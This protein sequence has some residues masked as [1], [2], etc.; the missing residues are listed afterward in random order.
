MKEHG[1]LFRTDMVRAILEGGKT[2]TRRLV[3]L[4]PDKNHPEWPWQPLD[5]I[6][7]KEGPGWVTLMQRNPGRGGM[8]DYPMHKGDRLWVRETW[9]HDANGYCKDHKCG[10]PDHIWYKA[11]ESKIVADSFAGDAH[12]RSSMFMPRWASRLD[13]EILS[14]RAERLQDITEKDAKAEGAPL[15]R[16]IG[17]GRLGM[18]SHKEGFMELWDSINAKPGRTWLDNPFVWVLEFKRSKI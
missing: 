10:N 1:I 12:W 18:K 14:V 2:Q 4:R 6:P 15:G 8:I 7:M 3:R 11:N 5:M 17:Y 9:A 16:V 13:L